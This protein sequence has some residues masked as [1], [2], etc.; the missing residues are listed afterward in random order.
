MINTKQYQLILTNQL[1]L[2]IDEQSMAINVNMTIS[3]PININQLH[4]SIIGI[5]SSILI[6]G[7][8]VQYIEST[9]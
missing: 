7:W 9:C 5:V 3:I 6:V 4:V 2:E 8:D 1:V